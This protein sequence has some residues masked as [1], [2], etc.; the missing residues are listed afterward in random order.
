MRARPRFLTPCVLATLVCA[1]ASPAAGPNRPDEPLARE[2]SLGKAVRFLDA[3]SLAWQR[4]RKCFACHTDYAYLLAR[5]AVSHRAPA[6]ARIRAAA[7]HLATHPR[8]THYRATEAVMVASVLARNDAA[9]T[10]KL[11]PATRVALDRM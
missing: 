3:A 7:E 8:T 2:F 9:T 5:P 6:H 11:H 1:V 10:G 4:E